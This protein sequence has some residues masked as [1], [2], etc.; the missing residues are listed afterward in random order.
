MWGSKGAHLTRNWPIPV[1]LHN[2]DMQ[3][4]GGILTSSPTKHPTGVVMSF[5]ACMRSLTEQV[6][7]PVGLMI[8]VSA[9]H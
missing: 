8:Q 3:S 1:G 2:F 9:L 7:G 4:S 6:Q 5:P